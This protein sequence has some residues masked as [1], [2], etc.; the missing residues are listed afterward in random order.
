[1]S[2]VGSKNVHATLGYGRRDRPGAGDDAIRHRSMGHRAQFRDT[3]DHQGRCAHTVDLRTHL[4]KHQANVDDLRFARRVVD[5]APAVGEDC[6]HHQRLGRTHAG[7]V[8]PHVRTGQLRGRRHQIAV[9]VDNVDTHPTK[10]L[11]MKIEPTGSDVVSPGHRDIG[12]TATRDQWPEDAD[13]RSH[14]T[15]K[16]VVGSMVEALGNVDLDHPGRSVPRHGAPQPA[17]QFG[18]DLDINDGGDVRQCGGSRR[19][20]G[21]RHQL[22]YRVLGS[23]DRHASV[24]PL[25]TGQTQDALITR[26]CFHR[27]IVRAPDQCGIGP[28]ALGS[29]HGQSDADLHPNR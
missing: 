20:Q 4:D 27:G 18:H 21:G 3:I 17:E 8:Q 10:S 25:P 15:N 11:D 14:S 5:R 9:L 2:W 29:R 7:K 19:Q 12:F 13:G 22:Q 6:G 1:M 24:Q 28:P 16:V 23:A 26:V